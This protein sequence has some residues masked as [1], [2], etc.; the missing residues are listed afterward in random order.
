M[1]CARAGAALQL[2]IDIDTISKG[3]ADASGVLGRVEVVPTDTDYT[4]IIDYAHTPD[5]L[6]NII[7]S[8]KEFAKGKSYNLVWVR[9]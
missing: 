4:V 1:R 6:E 8:V 9:R 3:L 5:G 7:S 2:G